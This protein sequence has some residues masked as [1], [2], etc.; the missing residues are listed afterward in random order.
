ML[1]TAG[2][3]G[4]IRMWDFDAIDAAEVDADHSIDFALH[5]V[6]EYRPPWFPSAQALKPSATSLKVGI[7]SL[8]DSCTDPETNTRTLIIQDTRGSSTA[9][10]FTLSTPDDFAEK[11]MFEGNGYS[12]FDASGFT[13]FCEQGNLHQGRRSP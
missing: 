3:D 2:M 10:T 11:Y 4:I 6:C 12:H 8:V 1:V 7:R 5:P 9:V 13:R